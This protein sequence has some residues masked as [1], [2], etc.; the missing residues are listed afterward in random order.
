MADFKLPDPRKTSGRVAGICVTGILGLL[1]WNYLVPVLAAMA[2]NTVSLVAALAIVGAMSMIFL[3]KTFWRRLNIIFQALGNMLFGW[4]IEMNPFAILEAQLNQSEKDREKLFEQSGKLK[5]QEADL[6]KQ[7]DSQNNI[8]KLAE[9][10]ITICKRKYDADPTDEQVGYDLES[11]TNEWTNAKDFID[12]VAPLKGDISRLVI[13]ADKA[14]RKSGHALQNART[15]LNSQKLAYDT[16]TAGQNAMTRALRAFSGNSEMNNAADKALDALR[17]DI[18]AKIGTIKNCISETSR[19][20]NERDLND[21][22]KVAL[23]ADNMQ[24]L[25]NKLDYVQVVSSTGDVQAPKE[26]NYLKSIK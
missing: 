23:A 10:K 20:M 22:A 25:D 14:Y 11:S 24:K 12:K 1:V 6:V 13:F 21:A 5:A 26:Q 8:M 7:L 19:V 9:K 2:W 3:S 18:A 17:K 15:T 16:V 4:F